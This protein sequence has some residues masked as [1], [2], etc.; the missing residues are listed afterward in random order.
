MES[1]FARTS[2]NIEKDKELKSFFLN[3]NEDDRKEL[4]QRIEQQYLSDLEK[5][6][7]TRIYLYDTRKAGLFNADSVTF[8]VLEKE[9][10]ESATT[11][12]PSLFYKESILERHYY[13][14]Y[15]PINDTLNRLLGYLYIFL[16]SKKQETEKTVNLELLQPLS[17]TES[18]ENND[19]AFAVY[20]NDKLISQSNDAFPFPTYLKND[21]LKKGNSQFYRINNISQLYFKIED[22][23]T[24][25]VIHLHSDT[26]EIITLFSYIF[27][28]QVFLAIIILLYQLYISY[29]TESVAKGKFHRLTLRKRVHF[30]MLA[31]IMMSF[32]II[33][34]V[35]I[36]FF[37]EQ[38]R[39][40]NENKL[41]NT[42][43]L[44]KHSIQDYL[45]L[46]NAYD[47]NNIFD[48]V[49]R[50]ER[51][52]EFLGTLGNT[53]S[54][55]VN[56]YSGRANLLNASQD[57]IYNKGLLSTK[58]RNDAWHE[59][60][61]SGKS[62]EIQKETVA[63]LTYLSAYEPLRDEYGVTLGYLNI[64]FFSSEKDLNF[65]LSNIVVTLINLYA[66]IFLLSS[67]ITIFITRWITRTFNMISKQFALLN[68]QKNERITWN[69]DDEIG[70]L[71][72]E[73]NK[74][75]NKVE[76]N[77][78]MLAQSERERA[79]REMARQVAHEIKNPLTPMKLNIQFL[80]QAMKND[81]PNIKEITD[82]VA[83]SII[84]QINN[85]SYIASEFSNF[86]TM[87]VARPEEIGLGEL[88]NKAAELYLNDSK[89][90]VT[91]NK[92]PEEIYVMADH[93]Q[94]LR[95]FTNLLE[96][97]IQAIPDGKNGLIEVSLEKEDGHALITVK[98][99]GK[100][101]PEHIAENIFQPYFTTKS[102]GTGLGLA[103][104]R[105]II[106]FWK[107]KIWFE[108]L[109]DIGTT[110]FIRLPLI[111]AKE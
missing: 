98:D 18:A 48:S 54:I 10:E 72:D 5:K 55:D 89:I 102:S 92:P 91:I 46:A 63:G 7:S 111:K 44:A 41:Q 23:K 17:T 37:T 73:Y 94:M 2:N 108:T 49:C 45:K 62:I 90:K 87:P 38:Y 29:F 66:F 78:A 56:I 6:F 26:I 77:A 79:W 52:K 14:A 69:Y 104:T 58:M 42:M 65:Q 61:N 3:P 74:M 110:F 4:N 64:P 82:K 13:I 76:E 71:V 40:S 100:G 31:V 95:V 84:E 68:L 83:S 16:D 47:S 30:S 24:I 106:E 59:L 1:S 99:N 80:Q 70:M 67:L 86:A 97:A 15:L 25:V 33:G 11:N 20:I 36:I 39:T 60:N 35:T 51:F 21:T 8:D 53:Q 34:T 101:I 32:I 96:N 85:L 50:T 103:M 75:V 105:K 9:K 107:G 81:K 27:G 12:A 43:Q 22:K 88:L 28:L 93:S 19:Y 57:D 109:E